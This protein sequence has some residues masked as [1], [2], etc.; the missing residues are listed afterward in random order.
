MKLLFKILLLDK[1]CFINENTV[2]R[3]VDEVGLLKIDDAVKICHNKM[4]INK[5]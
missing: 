2:V 5:M 1:M 4:K 3:C